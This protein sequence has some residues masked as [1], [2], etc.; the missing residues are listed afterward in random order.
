[1]LLVGFII[2]LYHDERSPE[3]QILL[4]RFTN[5]KISKGTSH[6]RLKV[7]RISDKLELS[8]PL[9]KQNNECQKLQFSALVH[10]LEKLLHSCRTGS[11]GDRMKDGWAD[12]R[13]DFNRL[14]AWI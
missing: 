13:G 2:R 7:I 11:G 4:L 5:T 10:I 6:C 14:P 9:N 8:C 1:M 12:K 3:R